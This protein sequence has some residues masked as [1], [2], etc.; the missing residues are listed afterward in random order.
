MSLDT[1]FPVDYDCCLSLTVSWI[2][3]KLPFISA[4]Y[5]VGNQLIPSSVAV[6]L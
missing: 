2:H 1:K 6:C 5:L 4:Y 3:R